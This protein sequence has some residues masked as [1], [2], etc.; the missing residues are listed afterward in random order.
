MKGSTTNR[1]NET[2]PISG[3]ITREGRNTA[4]L[5]YTITTPGE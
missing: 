2:T 3:A 1:V 5:I 4:E